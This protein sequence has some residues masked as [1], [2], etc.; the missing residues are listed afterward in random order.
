MFYTYDRIYTNITNY[1]T[2]SN[3]GSDDVV[4]MLHFLIKHLK[5]YIRDLHTFRELYNGQNNNFTVIRFL[6][7]ITVVSK[8]FDKITVTYPVRG[9]THLWSMVK[10]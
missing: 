10:T 2:V 3:K 9:Y 5:P 8:I 1:Y 6:H 4:H 7:Y